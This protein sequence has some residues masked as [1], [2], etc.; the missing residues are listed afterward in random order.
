[1]ISNPIPSERRVEI[2]REFAEGLAGMINQFT[3]RQNSALEEQKAMYNKYIK[4]LKRD[5]AEESKVTASQKAEIH[6]HTKKIKHL[7]ASEERLT[8][9]IRDMELKLAAS[10]D[11]ARRLEEKY[12]IC[13]THLNA[14]IQEQQDLYTRSKKQWQEAVEKVRAAGKAQVSEA[15]MVIRKAE[16]IREQMMEKVRQVVSQNKNESSERRSPCLA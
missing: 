14:A 13:R 5:L 4:R 11:R 6:S 9:Q 12:E 16:V 2:S 7:Q 3:C 15:E 10:E 8:D 1:M